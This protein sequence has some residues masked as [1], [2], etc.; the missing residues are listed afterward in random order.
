VLTVKR[1]AEIL[2][3]SP[4]LVYALCARGLLRHERYGTG[5]GTIRIP[6]E[7]IDEFRSKAGGIRLPPLPRSSTNRFKELDSERLVAAWQK[8]GVSLKGE[9]KFP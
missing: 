1:T 9:N 8:H 2:T 3:V 5:R 4:G 6:E 7:S